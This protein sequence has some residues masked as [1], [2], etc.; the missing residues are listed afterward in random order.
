MASSQPAANGGVG[1]VRERIYRF[2]CSICGAAGVSVLF[3][4]VTLVFRFLG[5]DP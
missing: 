4:L 3:A 1:A 2:L 5:K